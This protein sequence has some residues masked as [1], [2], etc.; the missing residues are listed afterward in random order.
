MDGWMG[1][2]RMDGWMDEWIDGEREG[3]MGR[4]V[5]AGIGG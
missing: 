2:R 5:N 4:W 3:G 1:D